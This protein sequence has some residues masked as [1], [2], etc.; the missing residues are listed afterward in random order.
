LNGRIDN[1]FPFSLLS[2]ASIA[3]WDEE[4]RL[5]LFIIVHAMVLQYRRAGAHAGGTIDVAVSRGDSVCDLNNAFAT[6][7]V[8]GGAGENASAGTFAGSGQRGQPLMGAQFGF[9]AGAGAAASE[10]A[11]ST[12]ISR[13]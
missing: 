1:G 10:G 5:P 6:T 12:A 7:A 8:K 9:G 4:V 2:A 13:F 3:A 11:S